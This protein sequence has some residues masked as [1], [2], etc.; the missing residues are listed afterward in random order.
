MSLRKR[1][2]PSADSPDPVN[3]DAPLKAPKSSQKRK[4]AKA[5]SD[6][7][8]KLLS[9]LREA[10]QTDSWRE[11]ATTFRDLSVETLKELLVLVKFST[12][13]G[14][15][16]E[17]LFMERKDGF[18]Y[19]VLQKYKIGQKLNA[20]I[21][22]EALE[23]M[24]KARGNKSQN[25]PNA[26]EDDANLGTV[27]EAASGMD[28]EL[29]TDSGAKA[30]ASETTSTATS[31][32]RKCKRQERAPVCIDITYD[33]PPPG[34]RRGRQGKTPQQEETADKVISQTSQNVMLTDDVLTFLDKS[35]RLDFYDSLN[36]QARA[37]RVESFFARWVGEH[38]H[39]FSLQFA[40]QQEAP[41]QNDITSCG[42]FAL[43]IMKRLLASDDVNQPIEPMDV[44]KGLLKK[45]MTEVDSRPLSKFSSEVVQS[46]RKLAPVRVVIDELFNAV[47]SKEASFANLLRHAEELLAQTTEKINGLERELKGA[48]ESLIAVKTDKETIEKCFRSVSH[49]I[50]ANK[51]AEFSVA[52][53]SRITG[54]EPMGD[55]SLEPSAKRPR[56]S[57]SAMDLSQGFNNML[58]QYVHA[59]A[60]ETN[61]ILEEA[62]KETLRG[63]G[64][65]VRQAEERVTE[66]TGQL[67]RLQSRADMGK[68]I[69]SAYQLL[70]YSQNLGLD[71]GLILSNIIPGKLD[72]T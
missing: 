44:R 57:Q 65:R 59:H 53:H 41:Q 4:Y 6:E 33:T 12:D 61:K 35:V 20:N 11:T 14:T 28:A 16:P 34:E 60:E 51:T 5:Q 37:G 8:E 71:I 10:S 25:E 70:S 21:C 67:E 36:N 52:M 49:L 58:S 54:D 19:K 32:C 40:I 24:K 39:G 64:E 46:V 50:K 18:I 29:P 22:R 47:E 66:L 42:I 56:M 38:Y 27:I 48:Q 63:P 45:V 26:N 15:E 13:D 3:A 31:P 7:K 1:K 17:A 30:S 55:G 43:E 68:V 23:E 72:E 2:E 69:I 9:V 62:M